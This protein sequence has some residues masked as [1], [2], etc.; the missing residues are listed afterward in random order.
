LMDA[1]PA[2]DGEGGDSDGDGDSD[3]ILRD[4]KEYDGPT[5]AESF[6]SLRDLAQRREERRRAAEADAEAGSR[7]PSAAVKPQVPVLAIGADP[8]HLGDGAASAAA[9]AAAAPMTARSRIMSARSSRGGAGGARPRTL[10]NSTARGSRIPEEGDG[11]AQ[12]S[13]ERPASPAEFDVERALLRNTRK[14]KL[15]QQLEGDDGAVPVGVDPARPVGVSTTASGVPSGRHSAEVNNDVA[16]SVLLGVGAT[17]SAP[18]TRPSSVGGSKGEAADY[19]DYASGLIASSAA[20]LMRPRAMTPLDDLAAGGVHV[21]GGMAGMRVSQGHGHGQG[22]GQGQGQ[23]LSGGG[24]IGQ[25]GLRVLQPRPAAQYV[26][27]GM[28]D[29]PGQPLW[30]QA[31]LPAPEP[32]L[33]T[34]DPSLAS[35]DVETNIDYSEFGL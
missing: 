35:Y 8:E 28:Y 6:R 26:M 15:L 2:I 14:L 30:P 24:L 21:Q 29:E 20:G 33:D 31:P 13:S 3:V 18:S 22:Q 7:S 27:G 9:A 5:P 4:V 19:A 17:T 23:R 10:R 12:P 34:Y 16:L 11:V 1:F 25:A 32:S